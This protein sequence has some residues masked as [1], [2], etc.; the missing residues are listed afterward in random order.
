MKIP[1]AI[2]CLS[3][4]SGPLYGQDLRLQANDAIEKGVDFL[5]DRQLLDGSWGGWVD[6]W[7]PTGITPLVVYTLLKCGVPSEHPAIMRAFTWMEPRPPQRVYSAGFTLLALE[8]SQDRSKTPWMEELAGDLLSW[9]PDSGVFDYGS[10]HSHE[11][12]SNTLLAGLA[13]DACEKAGIRIPTKYWRKLYTGTMSCLTP[14]EEVKNEAGESLRRRGFTYRP[15]AGPSGSM[16]AAGITLLELCARN[17][18]DG[19]AARHRKTMEKVQIEC[20]QWLGDF[21]V[22]SGNPPNRSWGAFNLWGYE[23]VGAL[24]GIEKIG[25]HDWYKEGA[26]ALLKRQ[27]SLGSWDRTP[28][29]ETIDLAQ[30]QHGELGTSMALLFLRRA[31]ASAV[32]GAVGQPHWESSPQQGELILRASGD[33]PMTFWVSKP[34]I[35]PE[36][37]RYFWRKVGDV[38]WRLLKE[39]KNPAQGF[40]FQH[41]F[42]TSGE[43]Q[44]RAEAESP[45]SLF[46]SGI[47]QVK[48]EMVLEHELLEYA[49][50]GEKN[51]LKRFLPEVRTSS[52]KSAHPGKLAA[53]TY[54][55]T[56]WMCEVDDPNPSITLTLP[57]VIKANKVM[58]AHPN[59]M[60][61]RKGLARP[62]H[63]LILLNS[64]LEFSL[65]MPKEEN[66]K[67]I[68]K[69][70]KT[71]SIKTLEVRILSAWTGEVG[72]S[73]LGFSEI[74]VQKAGR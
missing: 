57:A 12:L 74:E 18:G 62:R 28:S 64:K 54:L 21:F 29:K 72:Q 71:T 31:T 34:P 53:D 10:G 22:T 37:V 52:E 48:I 27:T 67:G 50:D 38:E 11:D 32:S 69:L 65:E 73:P 3:T 60:P 1:L 43:F 8:A 63:L 35:Q 45:E 7:Y 68:L 36:I 66:R 61:F 58:F 51:L 2:L 26:T 20:L 4:A 70:P 5:L 46:N 49:Q 41:R 56:A 47:I 40:A 59:T 13:L 44:I 39:E 16:T 25:A 30:E 55:K 6:Q 15:G 42:G 24:R 17:L 33:T 19:L 9:M 14:V 23:R